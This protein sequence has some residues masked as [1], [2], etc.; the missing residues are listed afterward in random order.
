[1]QPT[2]RHT[3][4][5]REVI[6]ANRIRYPDIQWECWDAPSLLDKSLEPPR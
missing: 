6:S 2:S 3:S 1:M 5:V 4:R